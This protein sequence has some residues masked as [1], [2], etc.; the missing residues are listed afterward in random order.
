MEEPFSQETFWKELTSP[1]LGLYSAE[2]ISRLRQACVAIPGLGGVGGTH[3]ISLVRSGIGAFHLADFDLFERRNLSR[4]YARVDDLGRPKAEVLAEEAR[5]INP[6]LKLRVFSEGINAENVGRFLEGVD[7]L[8]D[9][10]E[11]FA[12]ETRRLVYQEAR[13]RGIPVVT[14]APLGFNASLL[15]FHPEKSPTFEEYFAID[16]KTPPFDQLLLFTLGLAPKP[17]FLK[18]LDLTSI[19]LAARRGPASVITCYLCTAL[20]ATETVRLILGRPGL[21]PVPHY[22]QVD[23]YLHRAHLGCLKKGNRSFTQRLK[24]WLLK[25]KLSHLQRAL[26]GADSGPR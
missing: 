22:F 6:Y 20:A 1:Q 2:E 9:G 14:A 11:F 26:E 8:V 3:L 10:I 25:R 21:R 18:Y 13:K 17:W 24:F 16:E 19:D 23:L 15:I 5:R 7:V 4:Q 12:L